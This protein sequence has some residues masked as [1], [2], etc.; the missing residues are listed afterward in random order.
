MIDVEI[1]EKLND[2]EKRIGKN[3]T[4]IQE[5][6][7]DYSAQSIKVDNLNKSI[8]KLTFTIEKIMDKFENF[9]DSNNNRTIEA[10]KVILISVAIPT[11]F[12]LLNKFGG[13]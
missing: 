8:D 7:I 3:E 4:D 12:F 5:I 1:Q 9:K 11:I 2:H 10:W 13:K 6:K